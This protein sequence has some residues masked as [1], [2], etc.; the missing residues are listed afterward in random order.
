[1]ERRRIFERDQI[2]P[3]V[4]DL[5]HGTRETSPESICYSHTGFDIRLANPDSFWGQALYFAATSLYSDAYAN[6]R[7][8]KLKAI[9]QAKVIIGHNI[10][11][12]K[13]KLTQL[14]KI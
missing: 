5:Y 9:I 13:G 10:Q 6:K 12:P 3:L 4:E 14:P 7:S 11:L 2:E 8:N 1:M